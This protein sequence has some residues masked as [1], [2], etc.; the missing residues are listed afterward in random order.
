MDFPIYGAEKSFRKALFSR[1]GGLINRDGQASNGRISVRSL[2]DVSLDLY[3]GDRLGLVGHNGAGKSTLLRV[4]AGVYEPVSGSIRI[5]GKVSSLLNTSPGLDTEDTGY[6]NIMSCGLHLG[7]TKEEILRKT[8]AI[9]NFAELGEYLSLPVRTYSAGMMVRLGFALATS[10]DPE[11]LILDEGIGAGDARFAEAAQHRI[12][13]LLERSRILI[14]ATHSPDLIRKNC[15]KALLL[16]GGRV[17]MLDSVDTVLS[18]YAELNDQ[19]STGAAGSSGV[20][21]GL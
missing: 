7:M 11:I 1:V 15:N 14:L 17:K 16:H 9:E 8:P 12:N 2:D 3:D 4:L 18:A 21:S 10:I 13:S 19:T 20:L 6:E 5:N